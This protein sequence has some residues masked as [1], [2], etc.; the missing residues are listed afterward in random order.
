L[1]PFLSTP[2]TTVGI[3]L[4]TLGDVF[5]LSHISNK[6]P[7]RLSTFTTISV[8]VDYTIDTEDGLHD[9]GSL[10]FIPGETVKHIEFE[11]PP[12]QDLKKLRVILSNPVNAELTGYRQITYM[13]Q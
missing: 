10:Q 12:I 1:Q 6:I 2:A 7:V 9:S 8:Y 4:A 13:I 5:D 3:G 11:I